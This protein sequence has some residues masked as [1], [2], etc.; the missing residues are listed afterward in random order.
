[1]DMRVDNVAFRA[2]WMSTSTCL[3]ADAGAT[4]TTVD[5]PNLAPPYFRYE[6]RGVVVGG[7]RKRSGG[8][9][10]NSCFLCVCS[11]CGASGVE[12]VTLFTDFVASGVAFVFSMRVVRQA[13]HPTFVL[14][15][16]PRPRHL[17]LVLV[18]ILV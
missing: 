6:G 1:V 16:A 3:C 7:D 17:G 13:S 11:T 9:S 5:Y 18:V 15:R 12:V 4:T 8:M 10:S 14:F 2:E